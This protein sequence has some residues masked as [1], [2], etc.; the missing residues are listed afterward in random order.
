[1]AK[2]ENACPCCVK[3]HP[4]GWKP[5]VCPECEHKFKGEGWRGIASHLGSKS[6]MASHPWTFEEFWALVC[7]CPDHGDWLRCEN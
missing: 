1:M 4:A 2:S 3:K 7:A 5:R 6:S